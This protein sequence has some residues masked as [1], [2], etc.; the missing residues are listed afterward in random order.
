LRQRVEQGDRFRCA[1]R[2]KRCSLR[3]CNRGRYPCGFVAREA[4]RLDEAVRR[5][6]P[7]KIVLNGSEEH[8]GL[9]RW[10]GASGSRSARSRNPAADAG[11]LR[12]AA[13]RAAWSNVAASAAKRVGTLDERREVLD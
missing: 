3:S 11:P 6:G 4:C 12:P 7:S 10:S 9:T 8:E 2:I 1:N 5:F 13:S